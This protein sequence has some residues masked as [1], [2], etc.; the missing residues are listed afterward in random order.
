[1]PFNNNDA[2]LYVLAVIIVIFVT[3]MSTVFMV[4]AYKEGQKRGLEKKKLNSVISSTALFTIAPSIAI[5]LTVLTLAGNMGFPI[6]WLRLSVVGA[7]T[8]ELPAAQNA[9]SAISETASVA[10]VASTAQGF[11]T[12][13]FVMTLGILLGLP[14]IPFAVPRIQTGLEK[15]KSKDEKW[16]GIL[17]D[18]LFLGLISAFLGVAISGIT[19]D[20]TTNTSIPATTGSILVSCLT[21]ATSLVLTAIFGIII[22]KLKAKWLESYVLPICMIAAMGMAIVYKAVLPAS[23]FV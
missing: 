2:F 13:I 21:F 3:I 15:I 16:F 20:R 9:A 6:P 7:I 22:K 5:L 17:S 18:S 11:S 10:S 8:Y 4:R 1:M 19:T 12:I 23:L 14:L